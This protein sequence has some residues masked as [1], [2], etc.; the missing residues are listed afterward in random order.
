[1]KFDKIDNS[2]EFCKILYINLFFYLFNYSNFNNSLLL[3]N[4]LRGFNI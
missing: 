2:I 1:M 3:K 4:I